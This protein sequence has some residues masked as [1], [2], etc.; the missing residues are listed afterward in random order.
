MV[1]TQ[2]IALDRFFYNERTREDIIPD[3]LPEND[4][5]PYEG[6]VVAQRPR[7]RAF[8][9]GYVKGINWAT[10]KYAVL[11]EDGDTIYHTLDE[12]RLFNKSIVCG[13]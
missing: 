12:L 9:L 5:I 10:G 1:Q 4:Q 6:A 13:K 3:L 11:H 8:E 7:S 2:A